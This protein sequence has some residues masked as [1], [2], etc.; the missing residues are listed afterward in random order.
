MVAALDVHRGA[1]S[2][3][4]DG[5]LLAEPSDGA[6]S[7][8]AV[9]AGAVGAASTSMILFAIG[10]GI[11]LSIVSPW[12][13]EGASPL[14]FGV[15]ALVWLVVIQ[16]LSSALGGFIAGRLR[17]KW[18]NVHT[19]EAFFRDTAHGFLAWSVATVAGALLFA[20]VSATGL[21][22]LAKGGATIAAASAA[23]SNGDAH[24]YF[25]DELFRSTGPESADKGDPRA[26]T[27]RILARDVRNGQIALAPEDKTYLAQLVAQRT[28]IQQTDAEQRV[29]SVVAQLNDAGQKTR[30]AADETRKR[31]AELS[32]VVAL[33][34]LVGAFIACTAAAIGGGI[35][36]EA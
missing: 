24:G 12:Q 26:E 1:T 23:G 20:S 4:P 2:G 32:I 15:T 35:R 11:G 9:L 25:V 30:A 13:G 18:R 22:G 31:G 27:A 3:G 17:S 33:S 19:H 28:G 7:W 5:A 36:D 29:D 21:A 16:W 10:G 6:V 14:T 34:M 8:S